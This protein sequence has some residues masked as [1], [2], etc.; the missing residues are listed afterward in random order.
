[1]I[2]IPLAAAMSGVNPWTFRQ[3]FKQGGGPVRQLGDVRRD[4]AGFVAAPHL[5]CG[6]G[7]FL[8]IDYVFF[9][10]NDKQRPN[11]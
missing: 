5:L 2:G 1:V 11:K 4:P 3:W 8:Q 6:L 9:Q 7:C 10:T